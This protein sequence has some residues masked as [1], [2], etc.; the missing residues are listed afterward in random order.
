[1]LSKLLVPGLAVLVL[2]VAACGS[3]G[4]SSNSSSSS[5]STTTSA[6]ATKRA[7]RIR[8]YRL[9][10]AGTAETPPGA[11]NGVGVAV[12]AFHGS[13]VLCWRFAHL[14][15]FTDA[16]FA[17]IHVGA[18]GRSGNVVV[19]LS[20]APRLHHHGCVQVSRALVNAIERSPHD[21]YVNIHSAQ[22]PSGAVRAQL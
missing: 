16:T 21:Y 17:H 4:A 1:M 22:Y 5:V 19:P 14:H 6:S 2:G 9:R 11:P 8:T 7:V 18:K 3:S 13:S 12:I 10:L 20:T 15:G